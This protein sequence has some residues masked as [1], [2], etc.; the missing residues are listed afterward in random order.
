MSF[1]KLNQV[2]LMNSNIQ[3][4]EICFAYQ[5]NGYEIESN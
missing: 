5:L 3:E 4:L 2:Y 1:G